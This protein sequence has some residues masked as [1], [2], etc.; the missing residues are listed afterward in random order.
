[1]SDGDAVAD[2]S[3]VAVEHEHGQ[4]RLDGATLGW[5]DEEGGEGFSIGCRDA[6][7]FKVQDAKVGRAGYFCSCAEWDVSRVDDF[8]LGFIR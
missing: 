7:V 2:I 1:M 3:G 4:L 5:A 6:E 8:T